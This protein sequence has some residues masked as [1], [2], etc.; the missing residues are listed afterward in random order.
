MPCI[1][2]WALLISETHCLWDKSWEWNESC[3][4]ATRMIALTYITFTD[5]QPVKDKY[6]I[7]VQMHLV[8]INDKCLWNMRVMGMRP[9]KTVTHVPLRYKSPSCSQHTVIRAVCLMPFN[10]QTTWLTIVLCTHVKPLGDQLEKNHPPS[11]SSSNSIKES[12][13]YEIQHWHCP[14]VW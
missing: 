9:P 4:P 14:R 3:V 13:S 12:S 7:S 8:S 11:F 10:P 5:S 6:T 1:H 2:T